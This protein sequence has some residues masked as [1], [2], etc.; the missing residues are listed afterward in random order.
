MKSFWQSITCVCLN[1]ILKALTKAEDQFKKIIEQYQEERF[2][3]L[4]YYG[5]GKVYLRQNRLV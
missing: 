4:A 3:C 5:V 1:F 2:G